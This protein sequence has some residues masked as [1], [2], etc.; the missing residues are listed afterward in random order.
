MLKMPF[1]FILVDSIECKLKKI[2]KLGN[3]GTANVNLY[4]CKESKNH[5]CNKF[6]VIKEIIKNPQKHNCNNESFEKK[7]KKAIIGEYIINKILKHPN[8]IKIE[9]IDIKNL[10]FLYK[11]ENSKDLFYYF[12]QKN[13]N[14]K[15]Y[16]K[17][18]IQ[19][20]NAVK[21]MHSMGIAHMDLKLENILLNP[22][23]NKIKLIDFGHSCFFRKGK[24]IIYNKGIKGT[25]Y[26]IPPEMWKASYMSD[27]VDIWCCGIL[28]YNFIYNKMPWDIADE[29]KD[30]LYLQFKRD[31]VNNKLSSFIFED[32]MDYGFNDNDS[33]II[34]DLFLDM[35]N[36]NYYNRCS[37]ND[38]NQKILKI[39]LE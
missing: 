12:V 28:L 9:G 25:E 33:C 34:K 39:T 11:Y 1:D 7:A 10:S 16:F 26:Y 4:K 6:Y 13:Y 37:I 30:E 23:E 19:V 20:I 8:I 24:N 27:K 29:Y 21:Y 18:Y 36:I 31:R 14:A 2:K 3:G 17:Y 32:P 35:L 22:I 5:I 38:I 15:L